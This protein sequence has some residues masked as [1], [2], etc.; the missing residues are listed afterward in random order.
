MGTGSKSA[1]NSWAGTPD[2]V[3]RWAAPKQPNPKSSL[4]LCA[5]PLAALSTSVFRFPA[6]GRVSPRVEGFPGP[7]AGEAHRRVDLREDGFGPGHGAGTGGFVSSVLETVA[8]LGPSR[9]QRHRRG[10]DGVGVLDGAGTGW[11]MLGSAL[12]GLVV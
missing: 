4:F 6:P 2:R 3:S 8:P 12:A 9:H 5:Q 7:R 1:R 11:A 10:E